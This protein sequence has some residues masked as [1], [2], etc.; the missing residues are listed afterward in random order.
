MRKLSLLCGGAR[1]QHG[2]RECAVP[3]QYGWCVDCSTITPIEALRWGALEVPA[4]LRA[5]ANTLKIEFQSPL[6]LNFM[7]RQRHHN[8]TLITKIEALSLLLDMAI[9]RS[10]LE[11]CLHC[12]N[13][14]VAAIDELNNG[15]SSRSMYEKFHSAYRHL[16]CGG[17]IVLEPL[18][19]HF[20]M[21]YPTDY[22]DFNGI[23]IKTV[24]S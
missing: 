21:G 19:I 8:K 10:G 13:K 9:A 1:Y 23:L 20:S 17:E 14:N 4:G 16:N 6:R 7:G 18:N 22:Y 15:A 2:G 11:G 12:G 5:L 24:D 3:K